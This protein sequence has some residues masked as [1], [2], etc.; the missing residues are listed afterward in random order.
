MNPKL[1]YLLDGCMTEASQPTQSFLL[2]AVLGSLGAL[3]CLALVLVCIVAVR[4]KKRTSGE[5]AVTSD[6]ITLHDMEK[7]RVTPHEISSLQQIG[8]GSFGVVYKAQWRSADVVVKKVR[9]GASKELQ[10]YRDGVDNNT[11]R[12]DEERPVLCQ[13]DASLAAAC[14][15][16]VPG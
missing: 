8:Q 2:P 1:V 14:A 12:R 7:F 5:D 13:P 16:A 4:R 10:V 3:V 15:T 11:S 9:L 6:R